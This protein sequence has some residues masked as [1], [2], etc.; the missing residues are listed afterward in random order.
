[1]A[2]DQETTEL[3]GPAP[4]PEVPDEERFLSE[5]KQ[6]PTKEKRAQALEEA[7]RPTK[8]ELPHV[9]PFIETPPSKPELPRVSQKD[10]AWAEKVLAKNRA[11]RLTQAPQKPDTVSTMAAGENSTEAETPPLAPYNPTEHLEAKGGAA[12]LK[13]ILEAQPPEPEHVPGSSLYKVPPEAEM[14]TSTRTREKPAPAQPVPLSKPPTAEDS[15]GAQ[16]RA[17][18]QEQPKSFFRNLL[19]KIRGTA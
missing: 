11:E 6:Y 3:S 10:E 5:E 4:G 13:R 15:L 2:E 14:P 19:N 18:P 16:V 9:P 8:P 12:P 7:R 17:T 1:M